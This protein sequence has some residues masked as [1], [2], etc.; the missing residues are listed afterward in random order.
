MFKSLAESR[1]RRNSR[2]IRGI[3]SK[4]PRLSDRDVSRLQQLDRNFHFW[5]RFA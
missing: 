4:S 1:I 3:L 5:N 2:Q